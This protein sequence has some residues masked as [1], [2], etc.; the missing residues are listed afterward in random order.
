[1]LVEVKKERKVRLIRIKGA[2]NRRSKR[3]VSIIIQKLIK[4]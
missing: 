2:N 4:A 1:M 3:R